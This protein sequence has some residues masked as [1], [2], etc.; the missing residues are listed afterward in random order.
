[1][2]HT[3]SHHAALHGPHLL[4]LLLVAHHGAAKGARHL[5]LLWG[6]ALHGDVAPLHVAHGTTCSSQTSKEE[7]TQ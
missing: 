3:P 4:L 1:L 5:L 6:E 2:H 7:N